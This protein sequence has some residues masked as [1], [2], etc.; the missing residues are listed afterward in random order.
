MRWLLINLRQASKYRTDKLFWAVEKY[1]HMKKFL[2]VAPFPP[3][4]HGEALVSQLVAQFLKNKNTVNFN[5]KTIGYTARFGL[6]DLMN[7]V[8][9]ICKVLV[10]IPF[11]DVLYLSLKR[12]LLGS[13]KDSLFINFASLC[14]KKIFAHVHGTELDRYHSKLPSVLAR[15]FRFT[16]SQL[17]KVFVPTLFTQKSIEG[18]ID[19][20]KIIVI[21]NPMERPAVQ[22]KTFNL[23]EPLKI[24]FFS[25][26]LPEKGF[27]LFVELA[28]T[29]LTAR[30]NWQFYCFAE[31]GVIKKTPP[32]NL[33]VRPTFKNAD[34]KYKT[35]SEFDVFVFPTKLAEAQGIVLLEAMSLGLTM[36]ANPLGG[37][38]ETM[39]EGLNGF[40]VK[41]NTVSDYLEILSKIDNEREVLQKV[42]QANLKTYAEKFDPAYFFMKLK[43]AM[44]LKNE[45][46]DIRFL[47]K[48]NK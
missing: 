2:I 29:A 33:E 27:D 11:S 3:P 7:E 6:F 10:L 16:Y 4:V 47:N 13:F 39:A 37:V 28:Q 12:S 20:R 46:V 17:S 36:I 8:L 35:L 45:E 43:E 24:Y 26:L 41:E 34:E 31:K 19:S 44:D 23:N 14:H 40:F 42:G 38:P 15:Y 32:S 21:S 25:H 9:G 30:K 48:E 18:W 22:K 1:I 5:Q